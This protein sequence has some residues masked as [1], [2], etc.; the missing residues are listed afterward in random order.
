MPRSAY[1]NAFQPVSSK[2]KV[3][4]TELEGFAPGIFTS[5]EQSATADEYGKFI[6]KLL[7]GT[8]NVIATPPPASGLA[9]VMLAGS[10]AW[11]VSGH[12]SFQAGRVIEL[13]P[14]VELIGKVMDP[15]RSRPITGATVQALASPA[16]LH[17]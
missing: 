10:K 13:E 9:A 14:A 12:S 4:A 8:Y 15:A 1:C 3:A 16:S 11:T 17:G 2:V 6:V 7:P 5:Y